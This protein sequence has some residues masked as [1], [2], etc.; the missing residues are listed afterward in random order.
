MILTAESEVQ[1]DFIGRRALLSSTNST[2]TGLELNS[3]LHSKRPEINHGAIC[4]LYGI[5]EEF[6]PLLRNE[7]GRPIT[8]KVDLT[9][10]R[11]LSIHLHRF[12]AR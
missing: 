1:R 5:Y 12:E 10:C 4:L 8:L 3:R 6:L 7:P 9:C 2:W 11:Y